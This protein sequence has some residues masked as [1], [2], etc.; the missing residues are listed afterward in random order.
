MA[1]LESDRAAA[2]FVLGLRA[3]SSPSNNKGAVHCW[4]SL[5]RK[6]GEGEREGGENEGIKSR[7][8]VM[9]RRERAKLQN[10]AP[11]LWPIC[12]SPHRW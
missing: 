10:H 3:A 12:S 11:P 2:A 7:R 1:P 6:R 4:N 5:T 9:E 8:G